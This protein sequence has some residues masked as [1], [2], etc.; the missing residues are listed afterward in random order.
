MN[1]PESNKIFNDIQVLLNSDPFKIESNSIKNDKKAITLIEHYLQKY[2]IIYPDH[3]EL[4][5]DTPFP[6]EEL[7]FLNS[8]FPTLIKM[9]KATLEKKT[10]PEFEDKDIAYIQRAIK[11]LTE[12]LKNTFKLKEPEFFKNNY[13]RS[14]EGLVSF[15]RFPDSPLDPVYIT[16]QI[17][18]LQFFDKHFRMEQNRNENFI[19]IIKKQHR[20]IA[21]GKDG[22]DEYII[23]NSKGELSSSYSGSLHSPGM[24]IGLPVT[25]KELISYIFHLRDYYNLSTKENYK[26]KIKNIKDALWPDVKILND[27]FHVIFPGAENIPYFFSEMQCILSELKLI[28]LSKQLGNKANI[29]K[30]LELLIN[31]YQIG[32][33]IHPFKRI[34]QSLFMAQL[35]YLLTLIGLKPV[36]HGNLDYAAFSLPTNLLADFFINYVFKHQTHYNIDFFSK[37]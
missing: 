17:D 29:K 22:K 10:I 1:S 33:C 36:F 6:L 34:N 15:A 30:Y 23:R 7:L 13:F 19:D 4:K 35:N 21:S 26:I 12:F 2:T 3:I 37:P 25:N 20:I 11:R 16:C 31:Y 5:K 18:G 14:L 8:L 32:I 27:G 28:L 9:S 24:I